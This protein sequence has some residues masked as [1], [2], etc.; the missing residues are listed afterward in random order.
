[1]YRI[2]WTANAVIAGRRWLGV[3]RG[4]SSWGTGFPI[5]WDYVQRPYR[6]LESTQSHIRLVLWEMGAP[7]WV[8][9][10]KREA[11]HAAQAVSPLPQSRHS[12]KCAHVDSILAQGDSA[13][14]LTANQCLPVAF[15]V[16]SAVHVTPLSIFEQDCDLRG[17]QHN[18]VGIWTV[19]TASRD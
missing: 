5:L 7:L 17:L 1:M 4:F 15:W 6:T 16:A 13:P 10:L 19:R 3:A 9:Q 11:D 14:R 8:K 18:A 2:R 12:V